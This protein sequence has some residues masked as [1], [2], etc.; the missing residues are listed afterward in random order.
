MASLRKRGKVYYASYYLDGK[1]CRKSLETSSY[2][3]AKERLRNFESAVA[4]GALD[5]VLPTKTPVAEI[6]GDY[7]AYIKNAKSKNGVKVDFWYL[8][9]IFGPVCP[10]LAREMDNP[11]PRKQDH[12]QATYL[13]VGGTAQVLRRLPTIAPPD[14]LLG[15]IERHGI[16]H[17]GPVAQFAVHGE[18][19][20]GFQWNAPNLFCIAL[21]VDACHRAEQDR[22]Q[23]QCSSHVLPRKLCR[24][25]FELAVRKELLHVGI[26][27]YPLRRQVPCVGRQCLNERERAF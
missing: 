15:L 8:R 24:F 1:E 26:E 7:A 11:S 25:G 4:H 23:T 21:G 12:L 13:E 5:D 19:R 18:R 27:N 16:R 22:K 14:D 17:G 10:L 6:V 2:Q 20:I 3:V 9:R